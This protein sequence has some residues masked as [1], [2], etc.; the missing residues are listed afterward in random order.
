MHT[1]VCTGSILGNQARSGQRPVRTWFKISVLSTFAVLFV[2]SHH[3][4][5]NVTDCSEVDDILR[6]ILR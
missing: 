3:S 1:D 5:I 6:T 4:S 2:T